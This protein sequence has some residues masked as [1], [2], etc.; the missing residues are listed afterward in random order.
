MTEFELEALERQYEAD[1]KNSRALWNYSLS[2]LNSNEALEF[3][4]FANALEEVQV[5]EW[6]NW[7]EEKFNQVLDK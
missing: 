4:N 3:L 7:F 6:I 1:F 5:S 2:L